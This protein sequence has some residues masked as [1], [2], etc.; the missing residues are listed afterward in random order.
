MRLT[1]RNA[2]NAQVTIRYKRQRRKQESARAAVTKSDKSADA[3]GTALREG[4]LNPL[5]NPLRICD[6]VSDCSDVVYIQRARKVYRRRVGGCV[7][8][9]GVGVF[10]AKNFPKHLL[11]ALRG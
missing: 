10:A 4:F 2:R 7:L 1:G 5:N 11:A 6:S 3:Y 9:F 8:T